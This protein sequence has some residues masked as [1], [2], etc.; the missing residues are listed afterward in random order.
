MHEGSSGALDC[1]LDK[2]WPSSNLPTG[3]VPERSLTAQSAGEVVVEAGKN[4]WMD[5]N[6][7]PPNIKCFPA[8]TMPPVFIVFSELRRFH[9]VRLV[10]V[11]DAPLNGGMKAIVVRDHLRT[12][13]FALCYKL[14]RDTIQSAGQL[15]R[16]V[17]ERNSRIFLSRTGICSFYM[18]SK[19]TPTP[20]TA[21]CANWE[22]EDSNR[23]MQQPCGI[24]AKLQ[25]DHH[26]AGGFQVSG[27]WSCPSCCGSR[28]QSN[29]GR[30]WKRVSGV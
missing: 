15:V 24:S 13:T 16:V 7:S 25:G 12:C 3:R 6:L 17:S 2:H 28:P 22:S 21:N 26:S 1:G 30:H 4:G 19:N 11:W 20:L 5:A 18:D 10:R 27:T 23:Q 29:F 8:A 14:S 9:Y